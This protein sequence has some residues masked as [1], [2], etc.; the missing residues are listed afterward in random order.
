M[1]ST[2]RV[3]G[4]DAQAIHFVLDTTEARHELTCR[5]LVDNADALGLWIP[6]Y[7]QEGKTQNITILFNITSPCITSLSLTS[8][9]MQEVYPPLP[10]ISSC[11]GI[12]CWSFETLQLPASQTSSNEPKKRPSNQPAKSVA[13][14]QFFPACPAESSCCSRFILASGLLELYVHL[15]ESTAESSL[16]TSDGAAPPPCACAGQGLVWWIPYLG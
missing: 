9:R 13:T 15:N 4:N 16:C 3:G 12:P 14:N 6:C 7:Q 5:R 2:L 11:A 8:Q 1:R 10:P